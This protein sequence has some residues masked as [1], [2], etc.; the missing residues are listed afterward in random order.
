MNVQLIICLI[1]L[2]SPFSVASA[3]NIDDR[4]QAFL[5]AEKQIAS[6]NRG[7]F[8]KSAEALGDYPLY[9]LLKYQWL[10]NNLD[11]DQEIKRYLNDY[12]DM[13][14]SA[15]LRRDWLKYLAESKRWQELVVHYRPTDN[16]ELACHYQWARLK[17]G[18]RDDALREAKKLWTVGYSQPK[19][20]DD[21]LNELM[22][23]GQLTQDM[24]WRRFELALRNNKVSLAR[25]IKKLLGPNEQSV[26]DFWL[27]VHQ[28]PRIVEQS[29][30]W[31]KDY[32]MLGTIFAYGVER[33]AG[34]DLDAALS[35]WDGNKDHYRMSIDTVDKVERKL[36]LS[37][38]FERR[39][40]AY[41]RLSRV[42]NADAA[43]R[44]WRVRAALHEQNWTHVIEA[45]S[46]LSEQEK[47]QPR[48][49]YWLARALNE[50]G[51]RE[52]GRKVFEALAGDRSLFGFIAAETLNKPPM[53]SD[54]PLALTAEQLANFERLPAVS[55]VAELKSM[56]RE[57]DGLRQWWYLLARLDKEQILV[58][59]KVAQQWGWTQTAV[60]TIAKAEYWDDVSLR[61]P[62]DY[63]DDIK[64]QARQQ[65]LD[66][67]IVL[68]L[69]RRESVFDPR[70]RS[71]AGAR[72]LMQIM[73]QTGR[74]IARKLNET[75]Q[76]EN[77]L[78]QP[79]VN[80]KYG[81]HY[82][83]QMLDRFGGHFAL[84]AAAYNA[85]PGRVD[86]WLPRHQPLPADIWMETIPFK[87]TREYVAAVLGYAMIYQLMMERDSI[88]LGDVMKDVQPG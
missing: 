32:R 61:F 51:Q 53:L 36:G 29:S 17:T 50:T 84:A 35:V 74:Q 76:S 1:G 66:P 63:L 8:P 21:L 70:A 33:L 44:E 75:W 18:F 71:P 45:L 22:A 37:M 20:C 60:F 46:G 64:K 4:R 28:S 34:S 43:A 6:I 81:T 56:G 67:A 40:G 72:G 52:H 10:K 16:A 26:A 88:R 79:N 57:Q 58:A 30:E 14:Y 83:K 86:R 41:D 47:N 23:S 19:A 65:A 68:G 7:A 31:Q 12:S 49:Q 62:L 85:G 59:A 9:P 42:N 55:L 38:A 27:K 11:R 48:W 15:L 3:M 73:P 87:E 39:P 54:R 82:Y 24:I 5:D 25:Y 2:L 69:I 80:V 13:R 77:S 78:Y